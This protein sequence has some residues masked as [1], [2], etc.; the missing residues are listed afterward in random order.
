MVIGMQWQEPGFPFHV[1]GNRDNAPT[2]GDCAGNLYHHSQSGAMTPSPHRKVSFLQPCHEKGE[3]L[4]HPDD[5]RAGA[6][7][8][9]EGEGSFRFP[10]FRVYHGDVQES[11]PVP[12]GGLVLVFDHVIGRLVVGNADGHH[13]VVGHLVGGVA[14]S[15]SGSS[16][17]NRAPDV[18]VGNEVEPLFQQIIFQPTEEDVVGIDGNDLKGGVGPEL[19]RLVKRMSR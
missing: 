16:R 14:G 19:G 12:V 1:Y 2:V 13:F 15:H 8:F 3:G 10:V 7:I 5:D 18:I 17:R 11:D 6:H 4:V 9:G